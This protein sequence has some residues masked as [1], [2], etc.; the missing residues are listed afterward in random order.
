MDSIAELRSS[1]PI[2]DFFSSVFDRDARKR[3]KERFLRG[4]DTVSTNPVL[5][6]TPG[7][8]FARF[9]RKTQPSFDFAVRE[10][11]T[12]FNQAKARNLRSNTESINQVA[13]EE[14]RNELA[15]LQRDFAND[16]I[17]ENFFEKLGFFTSP[18]EQ[19]FKE[20]ADRQA[21]SE[22][23]GNIAEKVVS[24]EIRREIVEQ[25]VIPALRNQPSGSKGFLQQ[26]IV[27]IAVGIG[28]L[29]LGTAIGRSNRRR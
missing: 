27:P 15:Q 26:N 21:E 18:A 19:Q 2:G 22:Q 1:S 9:L 28:A 10:A 11:N 12:R 17:N 5:K 8:L 25:Q 23:L 13:Q 24:T 16:A 4:V 29:V 3:T 14:Q 20:L 7:G 6:F